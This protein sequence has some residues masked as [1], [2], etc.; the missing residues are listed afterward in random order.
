MTSRQVVVASVTLVGLVVALFLFEN[1]ARQSAKLEDLKSASLVK[2]ILSKPFSEEQK[3]QI[4]MVSEVGPECE[5]LSEQ[6]TSRSLTE[7]L[8]DLQDQKFQLSASCLSQEKLWNETVRKRLLSCV[9][10]D[11]K[12][13]ANFAACYMALMKLKAFYLLKDVNFEDLNALSFDQLVAK[14]FDIM[15]EI[16]QPDKSQGLL[17]VARELNRRRAGHKTLTKALAMAELFDIMK[18]EDS[19][20]WELEKIESFLTQANQALELS[21][22]DWQIYEMKL[23]MLVKTNPLAG[24]KLAQNLMDQFP[25][26][27][28]GPYYLSW[29]KWHEKDREGALGY[30]REAMSRQPQEERFKRSLQKMSTLS[31][32]EPVFELYI[33]FNPDDL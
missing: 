10:Q 13:P 5:V 25:K 14:L 28:L 8:R 6:L 27:G 1:R 20:A 33:S 31:F 17:E 18:E 30:V 26:V 3:K 2:E 24:Q 21:P 11:L 23:F 15:S 4:A 19:K 12:I 16:D 22:E 32:S 7:L 9:N 29:F